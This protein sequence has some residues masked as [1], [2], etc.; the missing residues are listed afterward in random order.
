VFGGKIRENLAGPLYK[1]ASDICAPVADRSHS[2]PQTEGDPSS[3]S[4]LIISSL[5]SRGLFRRVT[6]IREKRPRSI[7]KRSLDGKAL[8]LG[9]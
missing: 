7:S 4:S 6:P 1:A 3:N 2:L 8:L 9:H 5:R